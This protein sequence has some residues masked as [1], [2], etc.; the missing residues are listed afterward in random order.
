MQQK[1]RKLTTFLAAACGFFAISTALFIPAS[2]Y[3][4]SGI[5]QDATQSETPSATATSTASLTSTQTSQ[6]STTPSITVSG[7][8]A[9]SQTQTSAQG[10]TATI[11]PAISATSGVPTSSSSPTSSP[12]FPTSPVI[13]IVTI[14]PFP[15][16]TLQFPHKTDTP[17]VLN[18]ERMPG[19]GALGKGK[20]P[21]LA[22]RLFRFW[23]LALL[24][25]VWLFL[26]VWF[27]I[28]QRQMD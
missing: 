11:T 1:S 20:A 28:A 13:N 10:I 22:S 3:P 25:I 16:F 21:S 6:L 8:V 4:G 15:S 18:A 2:A 24:L 26:A 7:T 19:T 12:V 5:L 17:V 23:P 9:S 14:I 27:V